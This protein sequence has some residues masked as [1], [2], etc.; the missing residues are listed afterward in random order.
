MTT[1]CKHVT[2]LLM[3]ESV[4]E[5]AQEEKVRLQAYLKE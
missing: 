5:E 1:D 4:L 2:T 3:Q